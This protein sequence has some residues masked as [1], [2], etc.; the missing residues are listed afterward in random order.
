MPDTALESS[1]AYIESLVYAAS[2]G[3]FNDVESLFAVAR[4]DDD[5]R[6]LVAL[7]RADSGTGQAIC[8]RISFLLKAESNRD[9]VHRYDRAVATYLVV[10]YMSN[11]NSLRK[12]LKI[13]YDARES[14]TNLWWA[15]I[16]YR[17]LLLSLPHSTTTTAKSVAAHIIEDD[18]QGFR[19]IKVRKTTGSTDTSKTEYYR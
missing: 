4:T 12:G 13:V 18:S 10:L 19:T 3:V 1:F 2:I 8:D 9:E 5:I 14:A 6:R 16:V 7:A 15:L 17:R 11:Q